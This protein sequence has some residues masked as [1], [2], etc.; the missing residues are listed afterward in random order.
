MPK[1]NEGINQEEENNGVQ[2]PKELTQQR[3]RKFPGLWREGL[4]R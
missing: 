4:L 2:I 1:P 3:Q